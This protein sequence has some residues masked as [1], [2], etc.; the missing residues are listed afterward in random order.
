MKVSCETTLFLSRDKS[1]W[2]AVF[3]HLPIRRQSNLRRITPRGTFPFAFIVWSKTRLVWIAPG[4]A[5]ST[6]LCIGRKSNFRRKLALRTSLALIV[7][8]KTGFVGEFTNAAPTFTTIVRT[9]SSLWRPS[10]SRTSS[11][12]HEIRSKSSLCR[13]F[14]GATKSF[15]L[16]AW[17]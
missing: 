15:T 14:S 9:Q 3:S 6:A 2:T 7:R 10:A 4:M 13:I 1:G 12:T 11:V 8:S 5:A 16:F 17:T